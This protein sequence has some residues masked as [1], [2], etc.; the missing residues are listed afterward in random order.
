MESILVEAFRGEAVV[1][2]REPRITK[3][4]IDSIWPGLL[5]R[6]STSEDQRMKLIANIPL[7]TICSAQS[8]NKINAKSNIDLFSESSFNFFMKCSGIVHCVLAE[9]L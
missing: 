8:L 9:S 6:S 3:S 1:A 2:Y 5:G 4:R 7:V